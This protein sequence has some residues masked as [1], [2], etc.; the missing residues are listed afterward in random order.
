MISGDTRSGRQNEVK[1]FEKLTSHTKGIISI[2]ACSWLT[3]SI[4]I[5]FLGP[6]RIFKAAASQI[7]VT[8]GGTCGDVVNRCE[9]GHCCSRDIAG[10]IG[11]GFWT[12]LRRPW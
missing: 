1:G 12:N 4:E 2:N 3:F 8:V 10:M 9:A 6:C 11:V 5:A 7:A